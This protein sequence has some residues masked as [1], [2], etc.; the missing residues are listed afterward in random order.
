MHH[1]AASGQHAVSAE[2]QAESAGEL[3]GA[4]CSL[5]GAVSGARRTA[6]S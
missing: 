5:G 3:Q 1:A 2:R 4:A 6:M